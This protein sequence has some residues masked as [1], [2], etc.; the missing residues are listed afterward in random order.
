MQGVLSTGSEVAWT[1]L[2]FFWKAAWAFVLGYA[3]SAMIRTFV[4]RH[5][6]TS[7]MGEAGFR[8]AGIATAFGAFAVQERRAWSHRN[9][10]RQGWN[11]TILS[12]RCGPEAMQ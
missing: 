10:S 12:L 2:G 1:S 4:P 6:L 3:I 11:V 8:S 7:R 9:A 5:R